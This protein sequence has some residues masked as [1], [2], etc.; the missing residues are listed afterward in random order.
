MK[1]SVLI[2]G[3]GV[4]G[5][6]T[7]YWLAR[8]G[9]ACTIVERATTLRTGGQAVDVRGVALEVLRA[10]QLES[11]VRA[12]RTRLQGTSI[13][14][15]DGVELRRDE[16]RT[17]SGGRL[18][19][20]DIEV[21]R[22][23]LCALLAQALD[24]GV[25]LRLNQGISA[26][27]E[28]ADGLDVRFEDG[29][30]QR[31]DVL[32]GADGVYSNV[33]RLALDPRDECVR[34]LGVALAL[35]TAPNLQRLDRWEWMYREE[36]LGLVAYPTTDNAEL[37]VGVGFASSTDGDLRGDIA[38]QKAYT[39]SQCAALGGRLAEL[40][41][42]LPQ[43]PRF[44]YGD[45]AQVQLPQWSH[46][47]IAVVGDAAYCASPFSGQGTSLAL[48]GAFVLARELA[49]SARQPAEAFARYQERMRPY[50]ALNQALVDPTRQGPVPDAQLDHAKYGIVLYDLPAAA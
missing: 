4:A 9:F 25:E 26:L 23:D 39:L 43:T 16:T 15:R 29:Q 44:Y 18:D 13:L 21:F 22:D 35:F 36:T 48:V 40:M 31:Y 2:S 50:V 5:L 11:A 3:A 28:D 14:D 27:V 47:R 6:A 34:P 33:R 38:A 24:A 8:F 49:R 7:A 45:L 17:F 32:I 19:S 1:T 12:R 30:H 42:T 10:M 46:G 41:A 20:A 37:R